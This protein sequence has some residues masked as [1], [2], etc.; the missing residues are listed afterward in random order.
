MK[1]QLEQLRLQFHKAETNAQREAIKNQM[2]ELLEADS[3]QFATS[4]LEIATEIADRTDE[5]LLKDKISE[6]SEIVSLSYIARHYFKKSRSWL[7][8]RINGNLVNGKPAELTADEL[9]TLN[10]AFQDIS[11]KIGSI[12]L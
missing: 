5:F 4:M 11:K 7:H 8:Q 3:E 2:S 10:F 6:I 1:E 9:Q 12:S